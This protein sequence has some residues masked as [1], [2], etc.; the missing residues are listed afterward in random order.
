VRSAKEYGGKP[1]ITNV[2]ALRNFGIMSTNFM[3]ENMY[4]SSQFFTK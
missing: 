1:I 2:T 3:Y 4:L